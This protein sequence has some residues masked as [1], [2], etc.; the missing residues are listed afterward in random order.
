MTPPGTLLWLM[1]VSL[2]M[3]TTG[4]DT[5]FDRKRPLWLRF[6][7]RVAVFGVT[8]WLIERT[9]GSPVAPQRQAAGI[10]E[11]IWM[12]LV[13]MGRWMLGARC[14]R[15]C[16]AVGGTERSAA[17]DEIVSDLLTGTIYT[18]TTLA[19]INISSASPLSGWSQ[20]PEWLPSILA[21]RC[22]ARSPTFSPA[23]ASVLAEWHR[24]HRPLCQAS[25]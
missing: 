24:Y 7:I 22:K 3:L 25:R 13:E 5:G 1:L 10:D 9:I 20:R 17:R 19:V 14:R 2:L 15:H 16:A 6:V 4:L 18:A 12:Q 11:Q 8:P 21:L 23:S